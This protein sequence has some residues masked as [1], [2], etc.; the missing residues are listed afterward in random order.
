MDFDVTYDLVV[1]TYKNTTEECADKIISILDTPDK[2]F[3]V[4]AIKRDIENRRI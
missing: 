4:K 3:A 1:N 2:W